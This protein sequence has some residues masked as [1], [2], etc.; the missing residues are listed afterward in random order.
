MLIQPKI[1]NKTGMRLNLQISSCTETPEP[2]TL[3][4][5][6]STKVQNHRERLAVGKTI[7]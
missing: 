3:E 1:N 6:D 7:I 4:I 2:L 5:L